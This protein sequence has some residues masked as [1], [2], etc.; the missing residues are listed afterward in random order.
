MG[1]SALDVIDIVGSWG[2]RG[3]GKATLGDHTRDAGVV[4]DVTVMAEPLKVLVSPRAIM[5]HWDLVT[6]FQVSLGPTLLTG[7]TQT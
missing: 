5:L 6:Q 7:K 3:N 1:E 4:A 2:I